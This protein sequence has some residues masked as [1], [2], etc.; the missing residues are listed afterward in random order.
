VVRAWVKAP[1][2]WEVYFRMNENVYRN[3]GEKGLHIPFPQF[4][5]HVHD[6]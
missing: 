3:F 5:V 6:N 1:D 2:Y 4:D